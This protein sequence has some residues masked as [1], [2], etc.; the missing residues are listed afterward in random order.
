MQHHAL[1]R[2]FCSS[3]DD[4]PYL[5]QPWTRGPWT[6][7]LD[8][9]IGVRL[10]AF[11]DIPDNAKAPDAAVV[12]TRIVE[13]PYTAAPA[14]DLPAPVIETCEHCHGQPFGIHECDSCTCVCDACNGKGRQQRRQ[15]IAFE[16]V[17]FDAAHVRRMWTLP[18]LE[19][20][21]RPGVDGSWSFRFTGGDGLLMAMCSPMGD[22][23]DI[24]FPP[25]AFEA[26][27]A[28]TIRHGVG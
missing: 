19:V 5:K 22:R 9:H 24:D 27:R 14:I 4:R 23:F 15:T 13:G 12:F 18:G 7:A 6:Y 10:P 1:L 11:A 20:G 25:F 16:G 3:D 8:G 28:A 26:A 21:P 2:T 17:L